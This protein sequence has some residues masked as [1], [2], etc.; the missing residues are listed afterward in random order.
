VR[1]LEN[2]IER[3]A[4]LARDGR[5]RF[6]LPDARSTAPDK[7]VSKTQSGELITESDRR[8]RDRANILAALDTCR[9]KIFGTGGAAELLGVKPTTLASRIKA[10]G[11]E[12]RRSR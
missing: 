11:L 7:S 3:A 8:A 10:L 4:I 1:E 12:T 6:E 9:G 5:L 2:V